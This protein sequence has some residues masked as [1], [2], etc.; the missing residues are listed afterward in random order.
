MDM[1]VFESCA[2]ADLS[3]DEFAGYP[4]TVGID[5]SSKLDIASMGILFERIETDGQAHY[6]VFG[7]GCCWSVCPGAL[8]VL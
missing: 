2:D 8:V 1:R 7:R 5:L 3:I 4:A 6:Y